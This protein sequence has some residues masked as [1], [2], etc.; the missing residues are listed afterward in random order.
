MWPW[1]S[2]SFFLSVPPSLSFSFLLPHSDSSTNF[3]PAG[4]RRLWL[5]GTRRETYLHLSLTLQ[6]RTYRP[7]LPDS[8][9]IWITRKA[10]AFCHYSNG[11]AF[12]H[13]LVILTL[14]M[15]VRWRFRIVFPTWFNWLEAHLR[16]LLPDGLVFPLSGPPVMFAIP[17]LIQFARKRVPGNFQPV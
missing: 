12:R 15:R 6:R 9:I 1:F 4:T 16:D 13:W 3:L 8:E 14:V 5:R 10:S 17:S 11:E 7:V 2:S